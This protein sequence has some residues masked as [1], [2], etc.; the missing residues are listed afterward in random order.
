MTDI[1]RLLEQLERQQV[2]LFL[3][4]GGLLFIF[5][6]NTS[7]RTFLGQSWQIAQSL[8]AP[9]GF[10]VGTLG[11]L[12]LVS[13]LVGQAPKGARV[14]GLISGLTTVYWLVIMV[15]STGDIVGALP[16]SEAIFPTV[17]FFGVYVATI[18][19]YVAVGI[20]SLYAGVHSKVVGLL[21]VGPAA[22][23][24]LLM[25]RAAPNFVID[26]GHAVF[27]LGVGSVLWST[28]SSER[29]GPATDATA[30]P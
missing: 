2:T 25:A 4:A 21:V 14:A 6:A 23:F 17:F 18:L 1:D 3:V 16:A 26:I 9:A 19:A 15:G 5:A 29:V 27:H 12:S 30:N 13:G 11:L 28:V 8:I 24:L 22:M 7:A 20:V 10:L